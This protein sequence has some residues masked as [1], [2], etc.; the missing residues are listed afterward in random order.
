MSE[1]IEKVDFFQKTF[2][3]IIHPKT[4]REPACVEDLVKFYNKQKNVLQ[5][6]IVFEKQGKDCPCT[7]NLHAYL[8][9]KVPV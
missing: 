2:F 9:Y 8:H 3:T 4:D 7:Q 5:T 6:T 1:I